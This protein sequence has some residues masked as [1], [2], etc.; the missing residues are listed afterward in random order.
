M[1]LR[2]ILLI[3]FTLLIILISGFGLFLTTQMNQISEFAREAE[4]A[5]EIAELALDFN[6]ENFHTQLEVWEY[7]FEP[8]P[9]RLKAF[10]KHDNTLSEL[11]EELVEEV[12]DSEIEEEGEINA[13]HE[14]GLEDV[15]KIASN[16]KLVRDDWVSLLAAAG[17]LERLQAEGIGERNDI[18]E[19]AEELLLKE[20]NENEKLFDELEFNKR[21]DEF[22]ENQKGQA[23]KIE[24]E[25]ETLI[26]NFKKTIYV[27]IVIII[28]LGIAIAYFVSNMI[29]KPIGKLR[30]DLEEITKGNFEIQLQKNKIFE[31]QALTDSLTRILSSMKLAILRTGLKKEEIGIGTKE[32]LEGKAKAEAALKKSQK[33]LGDIKLTID[34]S[35]LVALTDIDGTIIY[36]NDKFVEVSKYSREELIGQNHRLIKSG[37]HS[38]SFFKD[39]LWKTISRGNVFTADIR[40]KAKDGSIYWVRSTLM[41]TFDDNKKINGYAAVRTPVTDLFEEVEDAI[42]KINRGQQVDSRMKRIVEELRNG[43]YRTYNWVPG[44]KSALGSVRVVQK[45]VK[46][47]SKKPVKPVDKKLLTGAKKSLNIKKVVS[48]NQK[49]SKK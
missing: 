9:T 45:T 37:F 22:V 48:K 25:L 38:A 15:Q 42:G 41:P 18:Y 49:I 2:V 20:V 21:V 35:S 19:D 12:E 23:I 44:T 34:N 24:E 32:A 14:G 29:T 7:A 17:E 13:L 27:L 40:N 39:R 47:V 4:E 28:L 6:V 46:S 1:K 33:E 8:N 31:V 26:S 3:G 10:Q 11:L 43:R 5:N 16:L 30:S 36:I